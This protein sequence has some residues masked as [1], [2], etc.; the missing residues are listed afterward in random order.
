VR[1]GVS[2][3]PYQLSL[4]GTSTHFTVNCKSR[5]GVLRSSLTGD[6]KMKLKSYY[7]RI[8]RSNK[9]FADAEDWEKRVMIAKDV[10]AALDSGRFFAT[11]HRLEHFFA[12]YAGSE[13]QSF[14]YA[15][16]FCSVSELRKELR[17]HKPRCEVSALGAC[18]NVL[19]DRKG[20]LVEDEL[21]QISDDEYRPII[22]VPA[23]DI[24]DFLIDTLVD[25]DNME[26]INTAW[27]RVDCTFDAPRNVLIRA[28]NFGIRRKDPEERLRD[29][30]QNII[31]NGGTFIPPRRA[32]DPKSKE[33][34]KKK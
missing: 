10:I 23:V 34:R 21:L 3:E 20:C 11:Q 13:N 26:L 18:F 24:T 22:K 30:M 25:Q 9:K 2:P 27:C 8:R 31:V 32:N 15:D 14:V 12:D 6:A 4:E 17:V 29:I 1:L 5:L 28:K 33:N 16:C 19:L 7:D